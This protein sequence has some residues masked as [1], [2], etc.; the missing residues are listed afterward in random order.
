MILSVQSKIQK[1][2]QKGINTVA[3]R[4]QN[5]L[6]IIGDN[7][8]KNHMESLAHAKCNWANSGI[9]DDCGAVMSLIVPV[10]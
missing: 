1:N 9:C 7:I 5:T 8:M 6:M 4:S 10:I 2:F 3:Q